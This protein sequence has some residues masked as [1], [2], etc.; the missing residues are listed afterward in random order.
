M[1]SMTGKKYPEKVLLYLD[2]KALPDLETM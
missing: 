2:R 1:V